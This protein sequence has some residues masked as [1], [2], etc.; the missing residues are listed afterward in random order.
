M[1]TTRKVLRAFLLASLFLSSIFALEANAQSTQEEI[2]LFKTE[3]VLE[4]NTDINIKE[5][6]H[7]LFPETR[8]GIIREI[9]TDYKVQ[10]GLKRPT[11]LVLNDIYYYSADN[12]E[13]KFGEYER[14]S[15]N[16]YAI[17]KSGI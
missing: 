9:T 5:E 6:I 16:G 13:V 3:V 7:Y 1:S 17:S 4:E 12:P 11:T 8:R 15:N 14:S 2:S 10:G